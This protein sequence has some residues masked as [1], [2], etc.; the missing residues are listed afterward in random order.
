MLVHRFR[1][2]WRRRFRIPSHIRLRASLTRLCIEGD[3][4]ARAGET[5]R[6]KL[7][8]ELG[9]HVEPASRRRVGQRLR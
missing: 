2:R 6:L 1:Q 5:T 4:V 9:D 8:C 7:A 3:N